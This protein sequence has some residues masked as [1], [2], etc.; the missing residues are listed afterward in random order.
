VEGLLCASQ[1]QPP[2][3]RPRGHLDTKASGKATGFASLSWR[4]RSES[5]LAQASVPGRL[6]RR[7]PAPPP[8]PEP[9][10]LAKTTRPASSSP[11]MR[12]CC[13]TVS[14]RS[15][16][17]RSARCRKGNRPSTVCPCPAVSVAV[18]AT[19]QSD[20]CASPHSVAL[21]IVNRQM[22]PEDR[23]Q[24][25][26]APGVCSKVF[27]GWQP[28]PK[29]RTRPGLLFSGLIIPITFENGPARGTSLRS[30]ASPANAENRSLSGRPSRRG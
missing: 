30:I 9:I 26:T 7:R 28:R 21:L 1:L 19:T 8:R 20:L 25:A 4:R 24:A 2:K 12:V 11:V 17:F 23:A 22:D 15:S 27:G 5:R 16:I 18:Y 13:P 29:P 10:R 6:R 3:S 14:K